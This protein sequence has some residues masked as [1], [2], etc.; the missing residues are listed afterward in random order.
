MKTFIVRLD[1]NAE[2]YGVEV[3]GGTYREVQQP[4]HIVPVP[5]GQR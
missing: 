1:R 5:G 2:V 4:V 3:V